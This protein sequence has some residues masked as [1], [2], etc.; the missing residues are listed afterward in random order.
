MEVVLEMSFLFFSNENIEFAELG[1]L[2]WRSYTV[3]A[4]LPTTSWAG[5]FDKREFTNVALN[6]SFGTFIVYLAAP[7]AKVL[8][9]LL[10][11]A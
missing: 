6:E 8:I 4:A 9:H 7:E 2:I 11:A 1:K 10:Q 5:F 3:S